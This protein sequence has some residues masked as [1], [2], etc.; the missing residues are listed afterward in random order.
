MGGEVGIVPFLG[1][2]LQLK[3]RACT[4]GQIH[5]FPLPLSHPQ[6][7]G[8]GCG[9]EIRAGIVNL[10]PCSVPAPYVNVHPL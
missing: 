6:E 5:P 2:V 1:I 7:C 4:I 3:R 9:S 8:I 10:T